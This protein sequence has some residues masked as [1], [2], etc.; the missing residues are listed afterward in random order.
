[1]KSQGLSH[2]QIAK[3]AGVTE[4]TWR[5][6]FRQ[7]Q[8]GGIEALKELKFRQPVSPNSPLEEH[9][10]PPPCASLKQASAQIE[11]LTGIKRHPIYETI[12]HDLPKSGGD[13]CESLCTNPRRL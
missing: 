5:L 10:R 3:L 11:A 6:Y 7:F 12:G 13:T 2:Q 1:L 9:F 8:Q 4:N